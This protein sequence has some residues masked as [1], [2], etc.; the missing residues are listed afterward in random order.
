MEIERIEHIPYD[1]TAIFGTKE[2]RLKRVNLDS[3]VPNEKAFV[4][5]YNS[6]KINDV[7]EFIEEEKQKKG[8]K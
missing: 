6:K 4:S 7:D 8:Y 2:C 3:P 1:D 5:I